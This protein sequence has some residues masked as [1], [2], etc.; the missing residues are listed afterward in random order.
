MSAVQVQSRFLSKLPSPAGEN[1]P[2]SLP[3]LSPNVDISAAELARS[4]REDRQD[5]LRI[6][7]NTLLAVSRRD[8][9][10]NLVVYLFEAQETCKEL[11]KGTVP[12]TDEEKSA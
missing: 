3:G 9:E 12:R 4:K 11:A 5:A 10:G 2:H 1:L 6:A 8:V 7:Y